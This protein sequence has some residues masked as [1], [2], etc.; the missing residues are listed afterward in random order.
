MRRADGLPAFEQ[1]TQ[2]V[3]EVPAVRFGLL[4][5]RDEEGWPLLCAAI[6]VLCTHFATGDRRDIRCP[7]GRT[8]ESVQVVNLLGLAK[9]RAA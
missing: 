3:E 2:R 7:F 5:G 1:L 4:V 8:G 6:R 9:L